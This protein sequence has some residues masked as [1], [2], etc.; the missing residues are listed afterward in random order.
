M[1]IS[2]FDIENADDKI[3]VYEDVIGMK[4]PDQMSSFIRRYNGG[5]TPNTSFR[6]GGISSDVKGFYGLG[7]VKYSLDKIRPFEQGG[8][9]YL[10]IALDSFGNDIVIALQTGKVAFHDHENQKITLLSDDLKGF[11]SSCDSKPIS[12]GAVKSVEQRERELIDKGRGH[13]ITDALRDMW[14]AEID[15]YGIMDLERVSI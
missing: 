4:L 8:N 1:Q 11:I 14:R 10:P 6:C 3:S 15:R 5:D 13:I 12:S 2:K 7:K 9:S